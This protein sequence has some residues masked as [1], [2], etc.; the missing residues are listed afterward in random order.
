MEFRL[1]ISHDL[2][3][4]IQAKKGKL[5]AAGKSKGSNRNIAEIHSQALMMLAHP[6]FDSET[7]KKHL[8]DHA[9]IV[10]GG[11]FTK[12]ARNWLGEMLN[13]SQRSQ[14]VFMERGDILDLVVAY[15]TPFPT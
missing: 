15:C 12:A 6:I 4:G 2:Y 11:Q 1:P 7:N 9:I 14:I 5:D 10:A 8:V 3:F 13:A